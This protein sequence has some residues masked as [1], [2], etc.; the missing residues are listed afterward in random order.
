M[1][2]PQFET[3]KIARKKERFEEKEKE[4]RKKKKGI[5]KHD[6]KII[7]NGIPK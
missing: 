5:I 2:H 1:I 4:K 7:S 6:K 3:R